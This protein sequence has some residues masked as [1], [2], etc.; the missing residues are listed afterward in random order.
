MDLQR[1]DQV[2]Q[3]ALLEAGRQDDR[4][5]RELGPIHLIKYVYLA[6]LAYAERHEGETFTGAPWIF[7]H[8]GPWTQD[9]NARIEP[10]LCAIG[11]LKRVFDS[12]KYD[13][14]VTRWTKS[15]DML[16]DQVEDALPTEVSNAVRRAVR[17][18]GT[19][20]NELL[21]VVYTTPPM[22][23]AKPRERL[24]FEGVQRP[25]SVAEPTQELTRKQEKRRQ[26]RL[27]KARELVAAR[28]KAKRD[29]RCGR[30]AAAPPRYDAVFFDGLDWLDQQAGTA[31]S[32]G[33]KELSLD[34]SVWTSVTRGDR[35]E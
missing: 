29:A 22:L 13:S 33:R 15:D 3:F 2:I 5:E 11:A 16:H 35:R 14:D 12:S 32:E 20:T 1:V 21:R 27:A 4:L 6:D 10:A 31:P 19:D 26:E 7:Y 18:F 25:T 23:R 34:D 28:L 30:A 17:K 9:V 24:V 8:Y